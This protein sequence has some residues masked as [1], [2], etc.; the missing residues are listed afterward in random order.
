MRPLSWLSFFLLMGSVWAQAF[1]SAKPVSPMPSVPHGV[2]R[3]LSGDVTVRVE[4]CVAEDGSL[5]PSLVSGSGVEEVD[6]GLLEVLSGWRWQ[7][8]RRDGEP[9]ESVQTLKIVLKVSP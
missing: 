3:R 7:P 5:E 6:E 9:V 1:E 2:L 4:L 8:A